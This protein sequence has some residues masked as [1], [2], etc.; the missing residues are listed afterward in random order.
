LDTSHYYIKRIIGIPGETVQ[1][2]DGLIYINDKKLIEPMAVDSII[3]PG[4]AE[5]KV[6]LGVDE[7]FLLGDNRNN[8]EDSRFSNVGNVKHDNIIGKAWMLVTSFSDIGLI[9]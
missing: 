4:L 8:S 7:Y 5:E 9:E 3:S 2:K 6:V 1:I